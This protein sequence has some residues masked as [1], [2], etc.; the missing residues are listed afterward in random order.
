MLADF[1][2]ISPD[3]ELACII[4]CLLATSKSRYLSTSKHVVTWRIRLQ[5]FQAKLETPFALVGV[6]TE[7]AAL[8]EIVYLP[9]SAGSLAPA[10]A[11]AE[12]ACAQIEKYAADPSYRF[13]LPL[14]QIGTAFQRRV[15]ELIASIPCGETRSYGE[16]ARILKSAPRA[17]G[18]A[19]GTNYFPLVIP[20]HRVVAANG[21]G[22]FAHSSGGYLIE[23]KRALLA[24]EQHGGYDR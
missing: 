15:W 5:R 24:H 13:E 22:G 20:C 16:F 10:N 21:I 3:F 12:Q 9:R 1:T 14:K 11:L 4:P 23:V 18:Q 2:R 8:A 7:G 17:V 6:R 19:C